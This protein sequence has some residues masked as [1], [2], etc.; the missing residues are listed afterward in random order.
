[1]HRILLLGTGG[2]AGHHVDEFAGIPGCSIVACVD[3]V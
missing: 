1:M 2:I 3:Q